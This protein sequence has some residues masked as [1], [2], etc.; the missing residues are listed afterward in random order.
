[1]KGGRAAMPEAQSQ[2]FQADV[3][4]MLHIVVHSVYSGRDVFMSALLS[5][6][7]AAC[8]TFRYEPLSDPALAPA[9]FQ[10][11]ISADKEVGTL[12]I[13]DN[14]IG[15]ARQDLADHLGSIAR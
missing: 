4:K 6:A 2:A 12:I 8:A 10:I 3:A 14:G 7:A 11:R 1:M 13:E 5:N 15:M 9:P